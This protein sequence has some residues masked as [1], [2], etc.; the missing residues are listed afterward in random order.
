MSNEWRTRHFGRVLPFRRPT[1]KAWKPA[2]FDRYVQF[3]QAAL[4]A[5]KNGSES[6]RTNMNRPSEQIAPVQVVILVAISQERA[7][8]FYTRRIDTWW[9]RDAHIGKAPMQTAFMET[10]VGG[11]LYERD[12]DGSETDW[13]RVLVWDRPSRLVFSWHISHE[14]QFDPDPDHASEVEVRF[15]PE[16]PKQ[17]RVEL[18]H[19]HFERHG[20]GGKTI[21]EA[22]NE[23]WPRVI[24]SFVAVANKT[25]LQR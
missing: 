14:F 23:G 20:I 25:T 19:R 3:W 22:V 12:I 7:F 6:E 21:R 1:N 13:G 24:G 11:R 17:T 2:S 9:P 10:H 5:F 16:G 8:D 15:V 4:A 18:T